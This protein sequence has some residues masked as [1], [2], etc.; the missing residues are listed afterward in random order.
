MYQRLKEIQL[1]IKE[2]E[3]IISEQYS[4]ITALLS[5]VD[6][7]VSSVI[8]TT[9]PE[10]IE[11]Q[12]ENDRRSISWNGG[13]LKLGHKSWLFVKALWDGRCHICSVEKIER[14]VWDSKT[15]KKRLV[16]VGDRTI[17]TDTIS[18]NTFNS[19]LQRLKN[20]LCGKF[21]YKIVPVKSRQT[22]EITAY[23]LKRTKKCVKK[24]K[25]AQ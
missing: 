20:G 6:L 3:Q 10:D 4:S 17:K 2:H 23:Q 22:L 15:R 25:N 11:L 5:E 9:S 21:P 16:K 13:C 19:F 1:K 8:L 12:F 24:L 18:R 7:L 14:V